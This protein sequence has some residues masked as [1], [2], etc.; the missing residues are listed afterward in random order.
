MNW[1]TQRSAF[2]TQTTK[3]L[4]EELSLRQDESRPADGGVERSLEEKILCLPVRDDADEIVGI[5]LA[6][7]LERAGYTAS[8]IQ[9]G[10]VEGCWQRSPPLTRSGVPFC[11]ASLR[12][13]TRPRHLP[14][15]TRTA[16]QGTD[17]YWIVELHR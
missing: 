16:V 15:A 7:L 3:D 9:I 5:M 14:E 2:I 11:I 4:V 10:S 17:H 6:E 12:D 13:L 8:A 1:M